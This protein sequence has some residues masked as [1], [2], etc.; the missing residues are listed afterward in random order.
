MLQQLAD[1]TDW[2][3]EII[4]ALSEAER[5]P[6]A[7]LTQLK[8]WLAQCRAPQ[9]RLLCRTEQVFAGDNR[10]C[11]I[12]AAKSDIIVCHDADDAIHPQ[13]IAL[14]RHWFAKR[15]DVMLLLHWLQ[16]YGYE[17][18]W[19]DNYDTVPIADVDE[20]RDEIS[21]RTANPFNAVTQRF[22]AVPLRSMFNFRATMRLAKIYA[23]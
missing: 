14:I 11:A 15:P 18:R 1:G 8:E 13:K 3:D 20:M 9:T 22:G 21:T 6:I 16:P 12:A 2:P 19:C 10:N 23:S 7:Q 4:V 5:A 17:W